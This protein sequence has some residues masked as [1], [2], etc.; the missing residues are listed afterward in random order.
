MG[1]HSIWLKTSIPTLIFACN[2]ASDTP[3]LTL[4]SVFGDGGL[5]V[6]FGVGTSEGVTGVFGVW[7][8]EGVT[9]AF[10]AGFG[11]GVTGAFEDAF[12]EG[13]TGVFGVGTFEKTKNSSQTLIQ[14]YKKF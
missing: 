12:S 9:G 5:T 2:W 3:A 4:F 6:V 13:D 8:G 7:S 14:I 10:G 1:Y 11:E